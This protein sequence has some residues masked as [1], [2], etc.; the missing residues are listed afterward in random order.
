MTHPLADV[1]Q[2]LKLP[3]D[4]VRK[5]LDR[6]RVT[7][8]KGFRLGN[9]NPADQAGD[10]LSKGHASALL[11]ASV[12]RLSELQERLYA[13]KTWAMLCI[14][15][16][17]DAAG[18]DG[19]IKH[20]MSGVNPQGVQVTSFKAPSEEELSHDFLWR[21]NRA[22][23]PRG[24]IGIFN[25]SHYEEVLVVRVHPELIAHQRLPPRFVTKDLWRE[26]L[27]AIVGFERTL[28]R[29]GTIVLKFF[30]H[31]SKGE[32][33]RRFLERLNQ[34]AKHWKFSLGDLAERTFW[35]RY[36][37]AY[38]QAIAAT[39]APHAPWF[40][41]PADQKWLCHLIVSAAMIETLD[42]LDLKP[43]VPARAERTAL[44]AARSK[45]SRER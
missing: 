23:P 40:V 2:I 17:M 15:Q 41:V 18:K 25:R 9:Y 7:D 38:E 35:N 37:D 14:F 26:R 45:L 1:A 43:P 3:R 44:A 42:R 32:Q 39:A 6:Y 27:D 36:Q 20:V 24:H 4:Q 30:L 29:Q 16:A 5:L 31:L 28:A 8:G 34:P 22:L 10:L 13:A 33:R 21:V 12:D 19:T 11:V